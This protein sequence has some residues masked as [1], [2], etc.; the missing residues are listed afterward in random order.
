[1]GTISCHS[2]QAYV[3]GIKKAFYAAAN[4]ITMYA[5]YQL[6][7]TNGFWEEVF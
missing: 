3:T 2:N 5:K 7:P 4:V 1:M 6:Y